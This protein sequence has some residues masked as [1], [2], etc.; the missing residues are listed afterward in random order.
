MNK[1]GKRVFPLLGGVVAAGLLALMPILLV[2]PQSAAGSGGA[3]DYEY[4]VVGGAYAAGGHLTAGRSNEPCVEGVTAAWIGDV[5][6]SAEESLFGGSGDLHIG[7]HG[8]SGLVSSSFATDS[9]FSAH[10]DRRVSCDRE[11]PAPDTPTDCS[12]SA[13]RRVE[14][15][16]NIGGNLGNKV[17]I[18]WNIRQTTGPTRGWVPQTFGCVEPFNSFPWQGCKSEATLNTFTE[19]RFRLRF[20]CY[21]VSFVPPPGTDYYRY[22]AD[23]LVRGFITLKRQHQS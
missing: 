6:T 10:H 18:Q 5:S 9:T 21:K 12:D 14:V 20:K 2:G 13:L 7:G 1:G 8:T 4:K 22:Q 17:R 16:A 11:H 3:A 23:S 15:D 19:Q